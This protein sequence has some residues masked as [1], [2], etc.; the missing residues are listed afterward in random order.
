MY[1]G[2]DVPCIGGGVGSGFDGGFGIR[3]GGGRGKKEAWGGLVIGRC[4]GFGK[5]I[6]DWK[7]WCKKGVEVGER[8]DRVKGKD[9][10]F[11]KF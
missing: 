7:T 9:E 2:T 3:G 6:F 11:H 10:A 5:C 8:N 1:G 4:V